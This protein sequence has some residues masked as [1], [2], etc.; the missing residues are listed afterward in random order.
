M[1]IIK[2]QIFMALKSIFEQIDGSSDKQGLQH[3][4]KDLWER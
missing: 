4:D 1:E 3:F 2:I